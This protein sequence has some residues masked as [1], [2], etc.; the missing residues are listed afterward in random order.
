[1]WMNYEDVAAYVCKA[2]QGNKPA[3]CS[4]LEYEHSEHPQ[5][6]RVCAQDELS[7]ASY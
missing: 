5:L 6:D 1:L 3:V 4:R 7:L 2:Y